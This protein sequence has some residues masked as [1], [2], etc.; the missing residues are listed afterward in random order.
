VGSIT[1]VANIF[2]AH[3]WL[4]EEL[5]RRDIYGTVLIIG[6]AVTAVAFG[7]RSEQSYTLTELK[8]LYAR[9]AYIV[10]I[11]AIG[12][13]MVVSY[14]AIRIMEPLRTKISDLKR[15]YNQLRRGDGTKVD[16]DA[17]I[18]KEK[19]INDVYASYVKYEKIHPVLYCMLAGLF[20]SQ[21]LIFAKSV[22]ELTRTSINGDQQFTQVLTYVFIIGMLGSIF[23]ET[24]ML[25]TALRFF[26]AM[27]V[28]PVF[29]CFFITLGAVAGG[30]YFNEFGR[31]D[32]QQSILFPLGVLI[33]LSGVALLST[34]EMQAQGEAEASMGTGHITARRQITPKR[35]LLED[36][37]MSPIQESGS[38]I[39]D[40]GDANDVELSISG[41]DDS[42]VSDLSSSSAPP[43]ME[44]T[45]RLPSA[46]TPRLSMVHDIR[47]RMIS[48]SFS[49]ASVFIPRRAEEDIITHIE[50]EEAWQSRSLRRRSA[51]EINLTGL[52][53]SRA[54]SANGGPARPRRVSDMSHI[55]R[56]STEEEKAS[57]SH[58]PLFQN[59]A[60]A[61]I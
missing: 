40:G 10:Y 13:V 17:V 14:M 27:Y 25:A 45:L 51:S 43:R 9:P 56:A 1:L 54:G 12:G 15:Q 48:P 28:V 22:A 11:I 24:H 32:T 35:E 16:L 60:P 42:V 6:G 18:R 20:G 3:F 44:Q 30:I 8:D 61:H 47:G 33:T 19:E 53:R 2:F 36:Q 23:I 55:R 49:F 26:D 59:S 34:R 37:H 46:F 29:Q 21:V 41:A 50:Q 57:G 7:D 5:S 31:F 52:N 58:D 39:E 38:E 4:K